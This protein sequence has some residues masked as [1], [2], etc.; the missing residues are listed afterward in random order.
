MGKGTATGPG[1]AGRL[2]LALV[3]VL[4]LQA[5]AVVA[6]A[7]GPLACRERPTDH[8]WAWACP[9]KVP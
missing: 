1:T 7:E 5:C 3:A 8:P 6:Q 9:R 4:A 2:V